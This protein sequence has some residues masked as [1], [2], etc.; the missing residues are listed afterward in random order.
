MLARSLPRDHTP[1]PRILAVNHSTVIATI[2]AVAVQAL[3]VAQAGAASHTT[4]PPATTAPVAAAP[5]ASVV[6]LPPQL[7]V[8]TDVL[9]LQRLTSELRAGLTRG[10]LAVIEP[11]ADVPTPCDRACL[12]RLRAETGGDY[13]LRT[14]VAIDDRDYVIRLELVDITTGELLADS[15]TR[16]DLCGLREFGAVVADQ[17]ALLRAKIEGLRRPPPAVI[18]TTDPPG[19]LITIDGVAI[20][21]SPIER[22]LVAGKHRVRANLT[23]YV[24]DERDVELVP[25]V[26]ETLRL[27]LRRD[28]R[29]LRLRAVGWTALFTG[30]PVMGAGVGLLA[31]AGNDVRDPCTGDDRDDQGDCRYVYTT[32]PGGAALLATG[33]VLGV[34]GAILLAR[35]RDRGRGRRV[36]ATFSPGGAGLVG[37]F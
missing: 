24:A 31:I 33:A 22:V 8:E 12:A 2:V 35:T 30:L 37:S 18:I 23:G 26:R 16:C 13:V 1:R 21:A 10:R 25:G 32:T 6:V 27:P 28:P 7:G 19:A 14:A 34:L 4:E 3:P 17:G 15:E 29:A 5:L 36:Q 20:G 9:L 11:G